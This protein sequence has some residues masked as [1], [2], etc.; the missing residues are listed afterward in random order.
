MFKH[1]SKLV[2]IAGIAGAMVAG[3]ASADPLELF[4][5][6]TGSTV[7]TSGTSS[8]TSSVSFSGTSF[9][10]WTIKSIRGTSSSP[11]V[12]DM[13]LAADV[14][15]TDATYCIAN[16]LTVVISETGFSQTVGLNGFAVHFSGFVGR[17]GTATSSSY[18]DTANSYF[19]NSGSSVGNDCLSADQ[20]GTQLSLSHTSGD[21]SDDGGPDPIR[22]YS[23]TI[24]DTFTVTSDPSFKVR[25]TL[26]VPEPGTLPL[27]GA[28]LLACAL[29]IDRRRR[30]RRS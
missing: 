20:I 27:L 19:C 22:S 24:A 12:P 28:G 4:L 17:G 2:M 18:Y 25:S 26:T 7:Q 8:G 29:A 11:S 16:P 13:A 15:C 10:G 3:A 14:S 30:A 9:Q 23:L 21:D 1:F 6:T 5:Q